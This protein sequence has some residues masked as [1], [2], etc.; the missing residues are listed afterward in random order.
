MLRGSSMAFGNFS[1]NLQKA[2]YGSILKEIGSSAKD[3]VQ[4]E[5]NLFATELKS[6]SRSHADHFTRTIIFGSLLAISAIPFLTFLIIGIGILLEER[7]WLSSLIVSAVGA[8]I[9]GP[10]AY[11]SYKKI[12]DNDFKMP[13]TKASL[14]KK[15]ASIQKKFQELKKQ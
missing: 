10:L 15:A 11:T 14:E 7:Y 8:L 9:S 4:S 13:H 2:T 3:L 1:S 5:I 12:K 6:I